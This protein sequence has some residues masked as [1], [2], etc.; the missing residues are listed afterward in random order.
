MFPRSLKRHRYNS[1]KKM[2]CDS[3]RCTALRSTLPHHGGRN[4]SLIRHMVSLAE[5][6]ISPFMV[7]Y[8]LPQKYGLLCALCGRNEFRVGLVV[9]LAELTFPFSMLLTAGTS[10]RARFFRRLPLYACLHVP[11]RSPKCHKCSSLKKMVCFSPYHA[12]SRWSKRISYRM[13]V[14]ECNISTF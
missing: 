13:Y 14:T 1:L 8:Q 3:H 7:V 4:G 2:V 6:N 12:A 5:C 11:P 10:L 9:S